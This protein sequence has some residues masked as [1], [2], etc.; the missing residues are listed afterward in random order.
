MSIRLR[1]R[2]GSKPNLI[3]ELST[4]FSFEEARKNCNITS[5]NAKRVDSSP[6][7]PKLKEKRFATRAKNHSIF[8]K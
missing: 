6:S 4:L 5:L 3:R 8:N 2:I 1:L 7:T